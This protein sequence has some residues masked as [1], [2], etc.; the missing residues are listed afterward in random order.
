[1]GKLRG[2]MRLTRPYILLTTSLFFSGSAFLSVN[3]IPPLRQFLMGFL[4]VSLA[5][6]AAHT[7]NDY[8]DWEV[9]VKNPRTAKRPIPTGLVSPFEALLSAVLLGTSAIILA[10]L[11]NI[12]STLIALAAVSLPFMY[13]YFRKHKIPFSFICTVIAIFFITL[14][15][16]ASVTGKLISNHV[17]LLL[18]LGL[19]W[20]TG[21]T[22]I[23][24]IQDVE[25]DRASSVSTL[26]VILSSKTAAKFIVILFT[27][28]SIMSVVIGI[29]AQLGILYLIVAF[30]ASSWLIYRSI[31]L[32]RQPITRNAVKMRISAPRY[33]AIICIAIT[34]SII[35][36]TLIV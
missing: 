31:E 6:A 4:A 32:L 15:G 28:T 5:I 29:L 3:G 11:L 16:S 27:S 7:F 14:F 21:R 2:L 1:M 8:S 36:N 34:I 9:D 18:I 12:L 10:F 24:E 13:N 33:L 19:T 35:S 23:S 20:E 17:P 30:A 26:S 25:P 22:L